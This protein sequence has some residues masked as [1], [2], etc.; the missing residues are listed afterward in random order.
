MPDN[1]ITSVYQER[2][3]LFQK[4]K[5]GTKQR[6][7]LIALIRVLFFLLCASF[8]VILLQEKWYNLAALLFLFF[9]AGFLFLVKLHSLLKKRK[10]LLENLTQINQDEIRTLNYD[11]Q[12]L[13][14]GQEFDD[15]SH[16]YISDLDIFGNYS[17]FQFIHRAAS[18]KGKEELA[19]RLKDGIF[20]K[21]ILLQ[22]QEAIRELKDKLDFRQNFQACRSIF[23]EN[24]KDVDLISKWVFS[25]SKIVF[26]GLLLYFRWIL[27]ALTLCLLLLALTEILSYRLALLLMLVQWFFTGMQ[28]RQILTDT[29]IISKS[30]RFFEKC[31]QLLSLIE[32]EK[33]AASLLRQRQQK[34][35]HQQKNASHWLKRLSGISYNLEQGNSMAGFI[36]NGLI[37][38]STQHLFML[39]K[40]KKQA[41]EQFTQWLEVIATLDEL[42]SFANLSFNFAE[43]H[44]PEISEVYFVYEA[45]EAGHPLIPGTERISNEIHIS[46]PLQIGLIT[47]ANMAGKSTY[48]RVTGVNLV[49]AMAGAAVCAKK[50]IFTPVFIFTSM[51]TK[52][53]LASHQSFFFAEINRLKS[54]IEKLNRGEKLFIL[55]DEILKGTNSNDQHKGAKA[56]IEQVIR[57]GGQGFFATHDISLAELQ[58][59]YQGKIRN[60]CFEIE[61]EGDQMSFDYRLRAGVS[62]NL[63]ASFLMKKMGITL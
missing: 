38:W 24:A 62:Q 37:L 49:L 9:F 31:S 25:P 41:K 14:D 60:L 33:F 48:L 19:Q 2:I 28:I 42:N 35:I 32:K 51:R 55:L 56:L 5:I 52:D 29:E 50:F 26:R 8:F 43:F 53:S 15:P 57:L 47:G 46:S 61:I 12:H 16:P 1:A 34:L 27:P 13:D 18:R 6:I 40:W 58:Q 39:E 4:E 63:N 11:F 21:E 45:E 20:E 23:N 44:F 10:E 59:H 22:R 7:N 54:L 17:L 30:A 36:F 3:V